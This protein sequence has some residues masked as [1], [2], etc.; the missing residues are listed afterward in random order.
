MKDYKDYYSILGIERNASKE[1]IKRAY[2]KLAL[3]YHPD[4]GGDEEKFKEIAEAYEILSNDK[5]RREYDLKYGKYGKN[6]NELIK[7]DF[8]D[9]FGYID[10]EKSLFMHFFGIEFKKEKGDNI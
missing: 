6:Y 8:S 10:R 7:L 3:K 4:R 5:K 2:K 9:L 1:E